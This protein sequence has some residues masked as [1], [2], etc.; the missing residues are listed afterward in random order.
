LNTLFCSVASAQW[1]YTGYNP[2]DNDNFNGPWN[3]LSDVESFLNSKGDL[4]PVTT[5][6]IVF[7][8]PTDARVYIITG[9]ASGSAVRFQFDYDPPSGDTSVLIYDP[10]FRSI[11]GVQQSYKMGGGDCDCGDVPV[12]SDGTAS[13]GDP[14]RLSYG[15]VFEKI[16]DYQTAG[17]N[18]L[19]FT[20]YYNNLADPATAAVTLGQNWRSIFDRYL[21]FTT[22]G[23]QTIGI[24]AERQD[25]Q[26][27]IFNPSLNGANWSSDADVDITIAQVASG[28]VLTNFDD[29]V[30]TY[31]SGSSGTAL[32][33]SIQARD[34]YTQSLQYNGSNQLVSV[35]DSF[36]RTLQFTYANN[37]LHTV[38]TPNGLILTYGYNAS[39]MLTSVTYST[40]PQTSKQYL[41]E[42]S[43]YPYALTGMI[44]ENGNRFATWTYAS[45]G[46]PISSQHAGGADLTQISYN[47]DSTKSV[48]NALGQVMIYKFAFI[49]GVLKV[50]EIDRLASATVP[51]AAMTYSYDSNGFISTQTDWNTNVTSNAYDV[52]GQPLTVNE[53]V[54]TAQ[55]RTTTSSYLANFHLPMQIAAPRKTTT[56]AYDASGNPL[57]ITETDTSTG[58]VPY[59]TTGQTRTWT[60]TFDSFGHVLTATGPRTDVTATAT[61]TYDASNNLSTV[62][63]PLG[64]LTRITSYNGSGLPL[65]ASDPNGVVTTF[66]YDA[67]DRLLSRTVQAT[68]G[69]AVSMFGYDAAGELTSI[70]FPD[71]EFLYYQY[72]AAH[73]LQSVSNLLGETITY[74]LD[75]AGDITNQTIRNGSVAL[76]K[77]QG[78]VFDQLS[79]MLQQIGASS[80]TTTYG[81]D[82]DGN[83]VSIQDGLTNSTTQ[84]FDALNR[85]VS[86]IDPLNNDTAYNYDAQDNLISV[87][88]PRSLVTGYVYDGFGKVIQETS[89][90]KGTTVYL[91]DNAGNRTNETDAR[92]IVTV[93]TFDKLNRVTAETFPA[94]PGENIS[95]SYDATSGGNLGIGHLTGYSDET[96]STTLTYNERDDVIS[97]TRTIG[98]TAYVTGYGYDLADHVTTVTYPS[99]HVITYG[100]DSQGRVSSVT[101]RPS[102]SGTPTVLASGVTYMPFGPLAGLTHGNGLTRTQIYDLDYRLTGIA[103]TGSAT[104][105]NLGLVYDPVNDIASIADNLASPYSQTFS[106]DKD[107][108][109]T[110]ALGIYGSTAYT[111][112]ADGNRLT[113]TAGNVTENYNYSPAA[114]ILQTTAKSGV[115]RSLAYTANGNLNSD[116]RGT[117][118][119]LIFSY[120]NRN[121]YSTLTIGGNLLA[122]YQY[123]ALG[124]RLIKTVGS[125]TMHYHYDERGHLIAES[126]P[127][128]TLIREYVWLDDMPLAQIESS[129]AIYYIHPDQLNHPQKMTDTTQAVVWDDEQQPF[130]EAIPPIIAP[131]GYNASKQ[132]QMT[133]GG[134]LNCSYIVQ[135]STSLSSPNWVSLATNAGPFNFTDTSAMHFS[136]RFYR[137]IYAPSSNVG[138]VTQNLR[139]PGQYFDA[140]SGLNYNMMRDYDPTLGRYIQND[141][142]GLRGGI[143]IF[144]YVSAN[145]IRRIDQYGLYDLPVDLP[146]INVGQIHSA[147]D[148]A[149]AIQN[150][151]VGG[152]VHIIV[153]PALQASS[154]VFSLATSM[155]LPLPVALDLAGQAGAVGLAKGYF[156][157]TEGAIGVGVYDGSQWLANNLYDGGYNAL[158]DDTASSGLN[159]WDNLGNAISLYEGAANDVWSQY[160]Q[161]LGIG[162]EPSGS[163]N[164][165][166]SCP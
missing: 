40:T 38:T 27:L 42:N 156:D 44:D 128:G 139:F 130:G 137:V 95:Y 39:T 147:F 92:G 66:T 120:G 111:Y 118:T 9:Q 165:G 34:G 57:T 19:S 84:A 54:G 91:L 67:R 72:D 97:T 103:T 98:G 100:R 163:T 20:R 148:A 62:T 162:S 87:T 24:T 90:D 51:A 37:L 99:G 50:V 61:Y 11:A 75:A 161:N 14:I 155:G 149:Q 53:A 15:N 65:T 133:V 110:Q 12:N 107:Y 166:N 106:Y 25:G 41:Y 93:R 23:G 16:T 144:G 135:A 21:R 28:W 143:N 71:G 114:N 33:N 63:D 68:S 83:R 117:S 29:T 126:R 77:T 101:Y 108:R 86:A 13:V 79:R 151:D 56:F 131:L 4:G 2:I 154:S 80:Q 58:T 125:M 46:L 132:F 96:G 30:E 31:N 22:S 141:P 32:L 88:D 129:G 115:T 45:F 121:R 1:G 73:R 26:E 157:F 55:A 138:S 49:F 105:Q 145:P 116:N 17:A 112:D 64:H 124:E 48:T 59:S 76:V 18:P 35:N 10:I 158:L 104:I 52:H 6:Q 134:A 140:E 43:S 136:A 150:N 102:I 7:W 127:G 82:S 60:N 69:N 85:L 109:L 89:P 159:W 8:A 146:R 81:Y 94:S 122:T 47:P 78:A 153:D 164:P 3:T 123:N 36:G 142:I 152:T 74:A 113:H 5:I 70:T 160:G 119:N